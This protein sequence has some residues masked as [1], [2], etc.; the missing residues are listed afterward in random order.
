MSLGFL[1]FIG[2]ELTILSS[3]DTHPFSLPLC[4][5]ALAIRY[6]S[7]L[8]LIK[9]VSVLRVWYLLTNH[10]ETALRSSQQLEVQPTYC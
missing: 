5:K 9:S 3:N 4:E 10:R 1:K 7:P 2:K 8:P 6:A